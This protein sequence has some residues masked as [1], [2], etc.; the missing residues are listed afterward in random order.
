MSLELALFLQVKPY[1]LTPLTLCMCMYV[2]SSYTTNTN[3]VHTYTYVLIESSILVVEIS[4]RGIYIAHANYIK[5]TSI[6]YIATNITILTLFVASR[7]APALINSWTTS[8][9]PAELATIRA[10]LPCCFSVCVCQDEQNYQLS[11]SLELALFCKTN[12]TYVPTYSVHVYVCIF[13]ILNKYKLCT[14]IHVCAPRVQYIVVEV[15]CQGIYM[16]HANYIK[17]TSICYIA[18]NITILTHLVFASRLAPALINSWTTST[19]PAELASIR[20]VSPY[21]FSVCVCQDEQNYQLSTSLELA[22]FCKTN[23]TYVPTYSVHVYV[24][25]FIIHN[26]YKLCTYIHVCA[27]R[28]QYIVVKVGCRGINIT[29]AN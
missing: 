22:L 24:C 23:L 2:S 3:Y 13:I 19:W 17:T 28:V 8:T 5:T 12:L 6:C 14:Y 26:K 10:V 7:L 4:C 21:C 27:P 15:S 11:T 18:T 25:I 16:A 9:W 1:L 20:A 29:H